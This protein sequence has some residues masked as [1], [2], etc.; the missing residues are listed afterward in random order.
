MMVAMVM[1]EMGLLEDPINPTIR[2]ETV[3][4]KAPNNTTRMP[5]NNLLSTPFPG[6]CGMMAMS[7]IRPRLPHNTIFTDRSFSVR[8]TFCNPSFPD[9]TDPRLPLKDEMMVGMVLIRVMKP[10]AAT[11]PAPICRTNAL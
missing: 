4:K 11:A 3:T 8:M 5:I 10:P 7:K 9:R 1:P 2:E 6:T